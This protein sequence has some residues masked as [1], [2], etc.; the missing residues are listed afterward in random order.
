MSLFPFRCGNLNFSSGEFCHNC[1]RPRY[2]S[3]T[4]VE[5]IAFSMKGKGLRDNHPLRLYL[6]LHF[7]N[8]AVVTGADRQLEESSTKRVLSGYVHGEWAR[9]SASCWARQN[10][11]CILKD[12]RLWSLHSW[13]NGSSV[14]F[15]G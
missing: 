11:I 3:V 14:F 1:K 6:S 5:G 2:S 8:V 12:V 15:A 13:Y 10:E 7:L 9:C 4:T